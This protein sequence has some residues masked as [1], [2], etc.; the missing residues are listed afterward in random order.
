MIDKAEM[1]AK[2]DTELNAILHNLKYYSSQAGSQVASVFV[3]DYCNSPNHIMPLVFEYD[4]SLIKM[5]SDWRACT[6]NGIYVVHSF[7][8]ENPLRAIACCLILVLQDK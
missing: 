5:L 7:D 4:V 3:P 1:G 2:T 8:D 6:N